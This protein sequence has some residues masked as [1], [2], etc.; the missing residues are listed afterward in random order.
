MIG[1]AAGR[2]QKRLLPNSGFYIYRGKN[3]GKNMLEC[4]ESLVNTVFLKDCFYS[5]KESRLSFHHVPTR[6]NKTMKSPENKGIAVYSVSSGVILAGV[7]NRVYPGNRGK[8]GV[9][10]YSDN[11][12]IS[13]KNKR[14][15]SGDGAV[16][17]LCVRFIICL[18]VS[19][20]PLPVNVMYE[21]HD[22]YLI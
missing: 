7:K 13:A 15:S 11:S 2:T 19:E 20:N 4:Q 22:K 14:D 6:F 8:I 1:S 10:V 21:K 16:P 12:M 17:F 5:G 9:K 3:R 18:P